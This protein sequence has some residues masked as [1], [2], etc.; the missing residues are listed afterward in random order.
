MKIIKSLVDGLDHSISP[1]ELHIA[2]VHT[3][4]ASFA[5]EGLQGTG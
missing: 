1:F 3:S 2:P 4:S 5:F